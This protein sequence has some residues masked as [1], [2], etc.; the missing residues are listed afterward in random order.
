MGTPC[1]FPSLFTPLAHCCRYSHVR[2]C[3]MPIVYASSTFFLLVIVLS[4]CSLRQYP[5]AHVS[6]VQ[7]VLIFPS[8]L[9]FF[10][11]FL[12]FP[13]FFL[14]FLFSSAR[15]SPSSLLLSLFLLTLPVPPEVPFTSLHRIIS[16]LL[17][18]SHPPS[19]F[20]H[21]SILSRPTPYIPSSLDNLPSLD[22]TPILVTSHHPRPPSP[23][24]PFPSL[25]IPPSSFTYTSQRYLI[26]SVPYNHIHRSNHAWFIIVH[27]T[28]D[29]FARVAG[30]SLAHAHSPTG[31][32]LWIQ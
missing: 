2:Y 26:L 9:T 19:C 7:L 14:F 31:S 12:L 15:H 18:S 24:L 10:L 17:L 1:H 27:P 4:V 25:A 30:G 8:A 23:V 22:H 5:N 29:R 21:L 11:P 13:F 16:Y 32:R 6:S 28:V 3:S 20:I